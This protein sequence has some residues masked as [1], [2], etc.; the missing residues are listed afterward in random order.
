MIG[1][2]G[3]GGD[4]STQRP[5]VLV[6]GPFSA[7][8]GMGA[9]CRHMTTG[10]L[11]GAWRVVP[12]DNTKT[13]A[14]DRSRLKAVMVHLLLLARLAGAIIRH[15]PVLVHIHTCSYRTFY[16]SMPDILIARMLLR[17][18]VLHIHGGYFHE[19]ASGTRGLRRTLVLAHLGMARR[20]IVLGKV[21]KERLGTL[22]NADRIRVV[23]NGV[24]IP[25]RCRVTRRRKPL[26]I[27]TIGD[28]SVG[29]ASEDLI[30]AVARL[31]SALRAHA[32]VEMIGPG[33][34]QRRDLLKRLACEKGLQNNIRFVGSLTPER[35]AAHLRRADIHVLPSRAE[36]LPM[37]LLEAMAWGL[38]SV[39]TRVGAV[40]EVVTDGVEAFIVEPGDVEALTHRLAKLLSDAGLRS[41]MG[42][43]ARGRMREA[44][45]IERF[46]TALDLVWQETADVP[47]SLRTPSAV[48]P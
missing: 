18:V 40:P 28:L 5:V 19:F 36:G 47:A 21:W 26:R 34:P 14:P 38:P 33:P 43:S 42:R 25:R 31:P 2:H 4:N 12:F 22:C 10:A 17:P 37:A 29:K 8:G 11:A 24:P 41:A 20:V 13:T 30:E 45:G 9:V 39:V 35:T 48:A 15:R 27:V 23:P 46:H 32:R 7:R 1:L 16:R 44:F 3:D 6:V